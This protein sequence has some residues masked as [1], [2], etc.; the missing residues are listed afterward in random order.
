MGAGLAGGKAA[1]ALR[2][3]GFDGDVV[4]VGAEGHAPYDRPP[5]SKDYLQGQ[6]ER[7]A[8]AVHEPDWYAAHDV[9]L[10]TSTTVT[11]IDRDAHQVLLDDGQR[12]G[13]DKLLL[14]T[15]STPRTPPIPGASLEGVRYLRT[16]DDSNRLRETIA[17]GGPI[18]IV[19]A[20]WIGLEVAAAARIAGVQTTVL[21]AA[22]QPLLRALGAEMGSVFADLHREHGVDLRL[23]AQITE[24]TG[25][26]R[27]VTGVA[28]ADGTHVDAAAVLIGIGATPNTKLAEQ[29]GLTVDDGVIVDSA[30]RTGDPD[31]YAAGDIARAHHPV[32][33][34]R[35]RVEHWNNALCQPATA[36]AAMLGGPAS[37]DELP[38]FFTDQYDLGMEYTGHVEPGGYDRVVVRGDVTT[39]EFIAFWTRQGRVVAGMNVN[40]WDVTDDIKALI[41]AA[42]PVDP[43]RLA[44]PQTP[45]NALAAARTA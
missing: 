28:L 41:H 27:H 31:I 43:D 10:R 39:R 17:G 30:L 16:V 33:D 4:L 40:I 44:D 2:E 1:E 42:T 35:I 19:G 3:Q 32:L 20:G 34:A 7:D 23:G 24:I 18:A 12:L 29:A 21:E 45:L 38:Y 37:Y 14:A 8:I 36:A 25:D 15:G 26:G 5:L 22:P 9:E 13:Y 11:G 6:T